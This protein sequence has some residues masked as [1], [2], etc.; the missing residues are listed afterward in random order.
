MFKPF[1]DLDR[2]QPS[3]GHLV[4]F[5]PKA[6]A[7]CF[8]R[9]QPHHTLGV[10]GQEDALNHVR[11]GRGQPHHTLGVSL[12]AACRAIPELFLR[13]GYLRIPFC[14]LDRK[15]PSRGHLVGFPPKAAA[16]CFQRGQPHHTL[17]VSLTAACLSLFAF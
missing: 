9:G 8:Q 15:Q 10:S 3:R 5:P 17:G 1:C 11:Q 4:G 14:D 7:E 12:T 2:K 16:E 6:A 13:P